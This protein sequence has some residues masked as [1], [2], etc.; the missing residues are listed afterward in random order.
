MFVVIDGELKCR[1]LA[2]T[3]KCQVFSQCLRYSEGTDFV[4][5]ARFHRRKFDPSHTCQQTLPASDPLLCEVPALA[6]RT[7]LGYRCL[8][9]QPQTDRKMIITPRTMSI[10][11][12]PPSGHS[13][14]F[15]CGTDCEQR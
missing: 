9:S 14:D 6:N 11:E 15:E 1:S 7:V 13:G 2:Q 8:D 4:R 10:L 5:R 12:L 3:A